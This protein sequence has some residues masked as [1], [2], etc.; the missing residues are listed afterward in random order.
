MDEGRG[1]EFS[2]NNQHFSVGRSSSTYS[3]ANA[4]LGARIVRNRNTSFGIGY[5]V[6]LGDR[7]R[8]FDGELRLSMNRYF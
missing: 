5:A 4:T 7:D 3:I 8:Q 2:E 6:P 1:L